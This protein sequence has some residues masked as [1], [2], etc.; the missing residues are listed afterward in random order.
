M[1][2]EGHNPVAHVAMFFLFVL[3]TLWQVLTGFAMYA[4]AGDKD[5]LT[6]QLFGWVIALFPNTQDLH[7]WH[8]AGM[9]VLACFV[10]IHVYITIR[11]DIMSRKSLISTMISGERMFKD[12]LP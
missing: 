1:K 6:Y 7:T 3:P 11:E 2:Y 5:A 10:L 4:E 8:H 12:D 9:W